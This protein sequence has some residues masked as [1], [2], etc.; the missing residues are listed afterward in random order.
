MAPREPLD[1]DETVTQIPSPVA[2]TETE[3]AILQDGGYGWVCV[4]AAFIVNAFTWGMIASYG[5]YLSYYLT[6]DVYS[7]ATDI[8]YA[9]VGGANFAA[10]LIVS[11]MVNGFIRRWGESFCCTYPWLN[12]VQERTGSCFSAA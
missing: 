10:A 9:F 3:P 5:V 4:C 7:N 12:L 11:P 6:H 8:D 2:V 1:I